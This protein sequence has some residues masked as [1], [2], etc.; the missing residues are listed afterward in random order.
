MLGGFEVSVGDAMVAEDAWRLRKAALVKLLALAP[1]RRMHRERMADLLWPELNARAQANNLGQVLHVARRVLDPEG[2]SQ[3]LR[4]RGEQITLF[5][6]SGANNATAD[7]TFLLKVN[8]VKNQ[9]S[10]TAAPTTEASL[11]RQQRR[12]RHRHRRPEDHP[13]RGHRRGRQRGRRLPRLPGR[14]R[15]RGLL[16]PGGQP[17]DKTP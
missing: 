13:G 11:S 15:L 5:H 10:D 6:A 17:P 2:S 8:D 16:R 12:H 14:L 9:P 3:C 1:A 4:L 7:E